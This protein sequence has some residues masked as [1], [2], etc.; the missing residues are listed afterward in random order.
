MIHEPATKGGVIAI[1]ACLW[2]V[3]VAIFGPIIEIQKQ[4]S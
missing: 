3:V 4:L 2:L 1:T